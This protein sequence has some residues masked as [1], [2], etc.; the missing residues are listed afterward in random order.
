MLTLG[1]HDWPRFFEQAWEHLEPGGWLETTETQFPP[2]RADG[3]NPRDSAMI[4]WGEHVYEAAA[5]AGIDAR[6]SEKFTDQLRAQGFVN[7]ERADV[8][9]PIKPWPRGQKFKYMGRLLHKNTLD[10]VPAIG[11]GL[12]TRRL[13]WTKEQVDE[14]C[15][16]VIKDVEA[17]G[18]HYYYPM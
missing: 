7:V 3:D 18:S 9:W 16:D 17:K 11:M 15:A 8:Q 2:R 12:F 4:T 5:T 1:M 10:A 13:G 6:A 14:F